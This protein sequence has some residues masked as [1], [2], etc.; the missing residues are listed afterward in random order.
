M[1]VLLLALPL[2]LCACLD[3]GEYPSLK[4]RAFERAGGPVD[5]P[6]PPPAPPVRPELAARVAA[7]VAQAREGQ[8][9]FAAELARMRSAIAGA[10]PADSESWIAAQTALSG[11]DA[12][13]AASTNAAAELDALNLSGVDAAGLRLGDNDF[14]AIR[15]AAERVQAMV[16][17]QN[18]QIAALGGSLAAP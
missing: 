18:D 5:P 15:A 3:R 4:P 7:L 17:A 2:A 12:R 9:A 10:G 11:L 16:E 6:A 13:R 8:S 1:R 14:A